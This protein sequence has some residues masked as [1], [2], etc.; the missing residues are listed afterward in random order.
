[1]PAMVHLSCFATA[2]TALA[3]PSVAACGD[4]AD[5]AGEYLAS[6]TARDNGCDLPN[7]TAGNSATG[8]PVTITQMGSSASAS[9]GGL[10]QVV[11]DLALGGHVFTG[12]VDGSSFELRVIGTRPQTMG[13]CTYTFD[14]E[15]AGKLAGDS[16]SGRLNFTTATNNNS[17]C[18]VLKAC[19]SFQDFAASRPPT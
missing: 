15:L 12:D 9:I 13:N 5:I 14:G 17:D 8:I 4:P 16:V 7:W 2:L 10:A 6:I 11:L 3:V 18:A 19:V 1:M